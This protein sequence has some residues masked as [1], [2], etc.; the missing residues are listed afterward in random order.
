MSVR[1]VLDAHMNNQ[2]HRENV[3]GQI[4]FKLGDETKQAP[5]GNFHFRKASATTVCVYVTFLETQH[6][7]YAWYKNTCTFEGAHNQ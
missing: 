1:V 7:Q 4:R 2:A 6:N 3:R 5:R